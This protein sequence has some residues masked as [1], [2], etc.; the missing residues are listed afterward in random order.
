MSVVILILGIIPAVVLPYSIHSVR[1]SYASSGFSNLI[2]VGYRL[3]FYMI[4]MLMGIALI[5][6]MSQ[7]KT[8]F[9]HIGEASILVYAGSTFLAPHGYIILN[10]I[11]GF[12][13]NN[14]FNLAMMTLYCII[15]VWVCA[16]PVFLKLY[17]LVLDKINSILFKKEHK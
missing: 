2:G 1:S 7:K 8:V 9:T 5:N 3:I 4:A 10:K 13:K 6:L 14:W 11:F 17:N 16:I 15:L 12:S